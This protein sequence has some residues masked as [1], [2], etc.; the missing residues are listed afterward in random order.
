MAI[1][2]SSG[3]TSSNGITVNRPSWED[4][5]K[6]YPNESIS[7]SA[8]YPMVSKALV[9]LVSK[10]PADWENT[11]AARMSYALNR[12]G[13][14]LPSSGGYSL[15]GDDGLIYWMRVQELKKYMNTRFKKADVFYDHKILN[16]VIDIKTKQLTS[17]VIERIKLTKSNFISKISGK[18]GIIVFDVT[19][20][21]NASGH[22]TLWDGKDLVYVGPGEH[23]NSSSIEYYFWFIRNLG[24]NKMAQTTKVSFWELK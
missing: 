19:G 14:K 10:S 23:N 6:N 22:F 15:K 11:C 7:S 5:Y 16:A 17:D 21:G 4:M 12:S 13:I 1:T 8:F 3:T 24:N 2:A 20:W 18:T 9:E